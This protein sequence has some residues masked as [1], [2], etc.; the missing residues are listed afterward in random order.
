MSIFT[1]KRAVALGSIAALIAVA[2]A[3]AAHATLPPTS[4][5]VTSVPVGTL[6]GGAP[7][8]VQSVSAFTRA[9]EQ[10]QGTNVAL[11]RGHLDDGVSTGWHTHPGPN[12][13]IVMSGGF[14]LTDDSCHTT[15]YG[16]GTAFATGLGVHQAV[17][18]GATEYYSLYFLPRTADVLRTDATAPKCAS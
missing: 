8:D 5:P 2:G 16:P 11:V 12:I 15:F 10:E 3:V 4:V 9:I 13:V 6:A 18:V 17:A 14:N 7:L 1:V